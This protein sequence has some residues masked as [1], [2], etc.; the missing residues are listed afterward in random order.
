V[1]FFKNISR[2]IELVTGLQRT[3]KWYGNLSPDGT[4]TVGQ[5]LEKTAD[6]L[7]NKEAIRFEG[8]A[9]TYAELDALANR[10]AHWAKAQGLK[11]GDSVALFMTN[12]IEY[13]ACWLGLGKVGVITA[14]INTNLMGAPLVHTI[15]TS[16][17][18][19]LLIGSDLSEPCFAVAGQ[20]EAKPIVWAQGGPVNGAKDLDA[21]L[22][23][24]PDTRP[25]KPEGTTSGDTALYVYTSG[26][27]GAPKA[28][29]MPHMRVI[30]MMRAFVGGGRGTETDRIFVTL[31]LYHAT[32]GICAVGFSITVGGTIILKRKFSASHF[33]DD[34]ASEKATVFFYIGELCRYLL[35]QPPH[36][37]E[38]K[39]N[40]RV[41][42]GNGMRP[43]VWER[44]QPRFK[45]RKIVEFY[46]ATEGNASMLNFDGKIGAIGRIPKFLKKQFNVRI[47]KFDV[48]SET[49]VRTPEGLC[50][51]AN[52]DEVGEAIG[53]IRAQDARFRFEGYSG[54]PKQTERKILRDVFVHGDAWF[55][56]G[57]LMKQDKDGYF[58]FIDRIGDTFR[59][60]GENVSTN[61]V[62]DV[63]ASYQ[64]VKEANVYGVKIAD[65]DGRAG[66][67][68]VS[69]DEGVD[70]SGLY[71]Y[72]AQNLPP[73]ARPIFL[74]IQSATDITGTFKYR[75][76]D[77][78]TVGFDPAKTDDPLYFAHPE[79]QKYVPMTKEL[80]AQIADGGFRF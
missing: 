29:R 44:F 27:T 22:A 47:V 73:Y 48:E 69:L 77:L 11:K 15:N 74:R 9:L 41:A 64:G 50:T 45:I 17:A 21:A 6:R 32:G 3:L 43:E 4:D 26:T 33:W 12:R 36:P 31:P 59:W 49:P 53:E 67:A 20:L 78:V 75:K 38:A 56:T 37:L 70:L 62:G 65:L 35:N 58:Y 57:D 61:E 63:L 28:A 51:E 79:Q 66:M 52:F 55:R 18:G 23:Q 25:Q 68:A 24:M 40:L 10:F 16:K 14:L 13:I 71:A 46:G 42:I 80:F 76:V 8:R 54:D 72:V 30:G 39:H 60:K 5:E 2:D 1:G 34:V 7:P 19:V